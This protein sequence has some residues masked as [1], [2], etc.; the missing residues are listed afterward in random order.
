MPAA[1]ASHDQAS[2]GAPAS[3]EKI[4]PAIPNAT[5]AIA[6]AALANRQPSPRS[7]AA[8]PAPAIA[9]AA[10]ATPDQWW[11]STC[12]S[13]GSPEALELRVGHGVDPRRDRAEQRVGE[14]GHARVTG[15]PEQRPPVRGQH[16]QE[17]EPH[18]AGDPE[19]GDQVAAH[20]PAEQVGEGL[21][22][23]DVPRGGPRPGASRT[24]IENTPINASP[25]KAPTTWN[26][27][28]VCAGSS[29]T[30][31]TT[32]NGM[33]NPI[34][35]TPKS[36]PTMRNASVRPPDARASARIST[37]APPP[38]QPPRSARSP[39]RDPPRWSPARAPSGSPESLPRRRAGRPS[40]A[41]RSRRPPHPGRSPGRRPR[42]RRRGCRSRVTRRITV[43]SAAAY[44]ATFWSASSVQK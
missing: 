19:P 15:E 41:A 40:P 16:P 34:V 21:G 36:Q 28:I 9:S 5:A 44:F 12:G 43:R 37:I 1:I 39:A 18:D 17:H 14:Q 24:T 25:A 31:A 38:D 23:Q 32:T 33:Y 8:S 11:S 30:N 7:D 29:D 42:P 26:R 10:T 27:W 13:V 2:E 3:P 20:Q 4:S 35:A 6:V 22:D